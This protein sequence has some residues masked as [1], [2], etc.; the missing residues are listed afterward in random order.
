MVVNMQVVLIST[1]SKIL[2]EQKI[3]EILNG[4]K[5]V[6]KYN[7]QESSLTDILEEAS[8]VSMFEDTKYMIVKNADF[9]GKGKASEKELEMFSNYLENPYPCTV[10]IFTTY[11]GVDKRKSITKK[12]LEK[13]TLLEIMAPKNYDL[14]NETKKELKKYQI[15]EQSIKYLIDACLGNYDL[16]KN[17]IDK[18]SLIFKPGEAITLEAMKKIV[19][20]NVNDNIFK[21]TDA[22]IKKDLQES[23]HLLNEFYTLK[24]DA[25]QLINMLVREYRQMYYYKILESKRYSHATMMSELK[26][27]DWQI[28]KIM[29]SSSYYHKDDLKETILKLA[30]MDYKIK[31]GLYEKNSALYSFLIQ[32][33]EY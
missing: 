33:L 17:E 22:V 19:A 25:L 23:L 28:N 32:M 18:L 26:L 21:F 10:L 7:Y 4:N 1:N 30:D 15:G 3:A 8:Y 31:S 2:L 14:L 29:K 9:F 6:V 11:D 24:I 5:N 16:I 27:Q 12:L 13:H 20:E